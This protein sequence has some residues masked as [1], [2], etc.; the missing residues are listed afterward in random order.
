MKSIIIGA[1]IAKKRREKGVTQEELAIH[2]GVSKPAVSKWE[3]G[4]CYPDIALLPILAAYFD[5]SVDQLLGYQPQMSAEGIRRLYL[6]LA[7]GFASS[8]F[9]VVHAECRQYIK[10]YFSCWHLLFLMGALLLNH[11]S[12]AGRPDEVS[13]VV[14]EASD[15]FLRV[16]Q[17]SNDP[18]LAR[19][20][21]EMRAGCYLALQQPE[22]AVRLLEG[23]VELP[24]SPQIL[25]AK[26]HQMSGNVAKADS[27]LQVYVFQNI[28]GVLGAAPDLLAL[29]AGN[30]QRMQ[31]CLQSILAMGAA[32]E[33]DR[34]HPGIY[35][36]I[37]LSAA[38]LFLAQGD[39]EQALASLE[40]YVN[41]LC[42]QGI[43]IRPR[44]GRFFDRLEELFSSLDLG[45]AA[46]RDERVII[47]SAKDYV[48]E[49]PAFQPLAPDPRYQRLVS[50]L[51][52]L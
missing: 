23:V 45:L 41:L 20:A 39:Q 43:T 49:N 15:L 32:L 17:E 26:A 42:S 19:Q 28:V 10:D 37:Y 38:Q 2:L 12:L 31:L 4:Q 8:P 3:S 48:L 11:A 13:A 6:R 33:M 29:A 18:V 51:E 14:Q 30:P 9:A 35:Y 34:V 25:L 21:L 40:D 27:L 1:N 24:T 50:R 36:P 16:E 44:G 46:P 22:Q 47:A 52:Q 5:I 7:E